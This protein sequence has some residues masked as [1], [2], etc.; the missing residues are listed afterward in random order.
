MSEPIE[1]LRVRPARLL[2][3]LEYSSSLHELTKVDW[4]TSRCTN[5]NFDII[6][7]YKYYSFIVMFQNNYSS[8]KKVVIYFNFKSL[9]SKIYLHDVPKSN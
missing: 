2:T 1:R 8:L 5:L 6:D 7:I 9:K 4:S 3:E